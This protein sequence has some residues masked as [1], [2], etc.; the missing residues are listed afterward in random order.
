MA[1]QIKKRVLIVDDTALNIEIM[2]KALTPEFSVEYAHSGEETLKKL[3]TGALPALILLDVVMPGMDGY[4][5]CRKLK[6]EPRTRDT[7]VIVMTARDDLEGETGAMLAY[8]AGA[9]DFINKPINPQ[10]LRQHVRMQILFREREQLL[11]SLQE[12]LKQCACYDP[13]TGL[14]NR[15]LLLDRLK[16]HPEDHG[17]QDFRVLLYVV[18]D[19]FSAIHFILGSERSA[20]LLQQV[21]ERLVG[22]VPG[23]D[24]V[25]RY[26]DGE[27]VVVLDGLDES[28]QATLTAAMSLAEGM[29][30]TLSQPYQLGDDRQSIP[31]RI[32]IVHAI[33]ETPVEKLL[34][35]AQATL[36]HTSSPER[37]AIHRLDPRVLVDLVADQD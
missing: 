12:E 34:R 27:F 6:A 25:A 13:V 37:T 1:E 9:E 30:D 26:A 14:P 4:E 20:L 23:Q 15:P 32:G 31:V 36:R 29:R 5:V 10:V 24:A 35:G 18:L 16:R 17:N 28:Q 19:Q 33:R 8:M 21:G 2:A 22:C 11:L 3:A 7:P